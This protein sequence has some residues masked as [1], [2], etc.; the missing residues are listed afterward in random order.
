MAEAYSH[1]IGGNN[2]TL[3]GGTGATTYSDSTDIN[4]TTSGNGIWASI[5]DSTALSSLFQSCAALL[6]NNRNAKA[7]ENIARSGGG[8]MNWMGNYNPMA[9]MQNRSNS[10]IWRVAVL[11]VAVVLFF[12]LRRKK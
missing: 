9:M 3:L 12:V 2:K 6:A 8:V 7:Q 11:V 4:Q 5:F 10:W 1:S